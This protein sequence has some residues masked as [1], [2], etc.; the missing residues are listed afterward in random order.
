MRIWAGFSCPGEAA[1]PGEPFTKKPLSTADQLALLERRGLVIANPTAAAHYL[2]HIGYYRF[3]GY[4][5]PYQ[6]GDGTDK[7]HFFRQLTTF[8]Q[9]HERYL[10]D[11]KLRLI[12]MDAIERIEISVRAK[13]S[14]SVAL[15]HGAHWYENPQLFKNP[16][17]HAAQLDEM[18]RQI[19]HAPA[20]AK[21]RQVHINHYYNK[22]NHPAMPPCWMVFET[23]T[24]GTVS[25][26]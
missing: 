7:H 8:E 9:I 18:K 26:I 22:Y 21:K 3:S 4:C 1:L 25:N 24:L 19:G 23:L 20:D 17:K 6:I 5:L 13:V 2:Q 12:L 14:D 11:R 15:S 16:V 10:F